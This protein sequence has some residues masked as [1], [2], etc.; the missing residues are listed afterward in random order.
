VENAQGHKDYLLNIQR[1]VNPRLKYGRTTGDAPH[2]ASADEDVFGLN[3]ANTDKFTVQ[4]WVRWTVDPADSGNDSWAN[5]ASQTISSNGTNGVFWL[6]HNYNN[7]SFE[8]AINPTGDRRYVLSDASKVS[9]DR[10]VWYLVTGVYDGDR[11]PLKIYV[12]DADVTDRTTSTSGNVLVSAGAKF[13]IGK[14]AYGGRLFPGNVRNLRIWVGE[15]RSASDIANDYADTPLAGS[16]G[17]TSSY[18]WPL[19]ETSSSDNVT[20]GNGSLN[21]TMNYVED[22]DFVA[23]CVNNRTSGKALVHRPA[24][25]DM[26]SDTSESVILV[27]ADDYSGSDFRFRVLGPQDSSNNEMKIWDHVNSEWIGSGDISSGVLMDSDLGDP[28]SGTYFWI[29]VQQGSSS[30]GSGR[31]VD[32]DDDYDGSDTDADTRMKYNTIMP[33]PPVEAMVSEDTF[34]LTGKLMGTDQY[35]LSKKYVILGY[36]AVEKGKLITGTSSTISAKG[37]KAAGDYTLVSDVSLHRIEVR[38]QD[39]VLITQRVNDEGW[40]ENTSLGDTTLPVELSTFTVTAYANRAKL[41][42]VSQSESNLMG[43]YVFRAEEQDFSMAE[44]VS[45]LIEATNST[46]SQVYL[47]TDSG[48]QANITYYYWLMAMDYSGEYRVFGP[49]HITLGDGE[50]IP[51]IPIITGLDILYPNPF[52]PT[53]SI[54]YGLTETADIK[55]SIYNLKGQKVHS[56]EFAQQNKGYHQYLWDAAAEVSGI[57]FVVFESGTIK[58]TRRITLSK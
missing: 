24:R 47:F 12:N 27:Q 44:Q 58:E 40:T 56:I 57:Y 38:T 43:Y 46:Q 16:T 49:V 7:S 53:L 23:C 26:S 18:S 28:A 30:A 14:M 10:G 6:Q 35:P 15:A 31:Y 25:M 54:R 55:L 41:Q 19:N 13:N 17:D 1:E 34:T 3:T 32:D 51:E 48:L 20:N 9:I 36:D 21:L 33:L 42:W 4:A 50:H 22:E 5:I 39:D 2:L 37:S 11:N 45:N 29:P 52:N 8:F